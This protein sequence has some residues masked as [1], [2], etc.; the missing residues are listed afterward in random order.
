MNASLAIT[1]APNMPG[2]SLP[3]VARG[4]SRAL[5]RL[6]DLLTGPMFAITTAM[7]TSFKVE[8]MTATHNLSTGGHNI[9]MALFDSTVTLDA[10]TTVYA[11]ANEVVGT[12]YTAG[13]QVLTNVTPTS[14]GT[15][16]FADFADLVWTS[17]TF[18]ARG[19][20][21]FNNSAANRAIAALDFG[22]NISVTAGNLTVAFP[23][24]NASAA[25]LRIG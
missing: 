17:S 24:A 2:V 9:R 19:G 4:V 16:A 8:L 1:V 21:L 5:R 23:T 3:G 18:V 15:T 25:V 22:A 20:L 10:T 7:C 11:T 12:G 13:G 6:L 14:S